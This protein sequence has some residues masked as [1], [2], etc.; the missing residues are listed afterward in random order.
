MECPVLLRKYMQRTMAAHN[1]LYEL[2]VK[3]LR[4]EHWIPT[5]RK[6]IIREGTKK[7]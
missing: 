1:F 4:V 6:I 2:V 7:G 5:S 3:K